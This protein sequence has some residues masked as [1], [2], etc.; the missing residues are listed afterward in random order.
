MENYESKICTACRADAPKAT[1]SQIEGFLNDYPS[2]ELQDIND[3]P[4]LP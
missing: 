4:K 2:W 3:I 1:Q